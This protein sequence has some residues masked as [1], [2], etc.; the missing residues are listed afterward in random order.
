[1]RLAVWIVSDWHFS[2]DKAFL[3]EPRGFTNPDLMNAEIV[4][5]HNALV[6][7]DDE[8][9]C[10]GDCVMTDTDR[11]IEFLKELNGRIHIVVGNHD[12][13][14]K[15]SKYCECPNVVEAINPQVL[16]YR[17]Y[18]FYLSHYPTLTD[19]YDEDKPLRCK[20]ICLCGHS[21]TA[22]K[23]ADMDKGIIYHC[24]L[25]AHD[26]K[27]V[28]LDDIIEDIKMYFENNK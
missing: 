27:P 12:S 1:M 23:F 13:P 4:R 21:H 22:D 8:V 15:I 28:L 16:K 5:R 25:E 7:P 6:Q 24:E 17:K 26:L 20:T 9:Y 3:L 2:H 11:G 14:N 10:L 19:N 18:S